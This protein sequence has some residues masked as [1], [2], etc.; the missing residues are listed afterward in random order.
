M[1]HKMKLIFE[2]CLTL[3]LAFAL[4]LGCAQLYA[5]AEGPAS[6]TL[7][8]PAPGGVYYDFSNGLEA[9]VA[10]F[11]AQHRM[12]EKNFAFG[13]RD[14][15]DGREYLFNG[16]WYCRAASMYKLP[17][18][19]YCFDM[20]AAGSLSEGEAVDGFTVGSALRL[21]V[22]SSHNEAAQALR[23][24]ISYNITEYRNALASYSDLDLSTLPRE[25]YMD[26]CMSPRFLLGTLQTLYDR[27]EDF[28][29]LLGYLKEAS[30]KH[31]FRHSASQTEVA[32][33]YGSMEGWVNDCGIVYAQRPFLLVAFTRSVPNAEQAL[34]ELRDMMEAYAD[35][36]AREAAA[37][38]E[39]EPTPDPTPA[40][41]PAP[42][43]SPVPTPMPT[44]EPT[45]TP[46]PTPA[47]VEET[48]RPIYLIPAA[49]GAA[50]LM[51][52]AVVLLLRKRYKPRH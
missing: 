16:D 42:T 7:G 37:A 11:M 33:K 45:P 47:P 36:L 52:A 14:L 41:T 44:A 26:N 5:A 24:R 18:A 27:S 50:A 9:A 43:P 13:W 12:T 48:G 49:A 1:C 15:T 10:D 31:Y 46:A 22:V 51:L 39:P 17:L 2:Y 21:A 28:P 8:A 29:T 3:C 20:I 35:H 25:Y 30:P 23:Y 34:G 19:M 6:D 4:L 38:A 32:H 40:P